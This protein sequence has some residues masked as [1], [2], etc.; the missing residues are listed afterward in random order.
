MLSLNKAGTFTLKH[1]TVSGTLLWVVWVIEALI[2]IGAQIL[3]SLFGEIDK[4][5]F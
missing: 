2:I 3:F 1:N 4:S 5:V